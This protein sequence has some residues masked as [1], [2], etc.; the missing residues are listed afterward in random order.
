MKMLEVAGESDQSA[1]Y[2]TLGYNYTKSAVEEL[3]SLC[4][5]LS[6]AMIRISV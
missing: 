5:A 1:R 2:I 4:T 6:P 3:N